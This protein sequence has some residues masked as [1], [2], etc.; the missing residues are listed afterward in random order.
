MLLFQ[1]EERN[2]ADL[3]LDQQTDQV[4]DSSQVQDQDLE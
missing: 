1:I 4:A 3:D 2:P